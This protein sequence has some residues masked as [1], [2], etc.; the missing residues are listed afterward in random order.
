MAEQSRLYLVSCVS[1][2]H[3]APTPANQF[4][5]SPWFKAVRR[6]VEAREGPWFVLSARYGLV[7]P[8]QILEPYDETLNKMRIA[9][10]RAWASRVMTQMEQF[11]PSARTVVLFAGL[12]YREFLT[13][14]LKERSTV[15]VPMLGLTIGRQLQWLKS[16]VRA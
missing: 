5:I 1:K 10:R 14:Y 9:D 3:P 8:T 15:E 12:C 11:M 13:D 16:E 4:Y 2:K 6:Y 7:A